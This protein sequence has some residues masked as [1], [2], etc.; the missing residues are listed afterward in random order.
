MQRGGKWWI[1]TPRLEVCWV[2]HLWAGC[3]P[4]QFCWDRSDRYSRMGFLQAGLTGWRNRSDWL[5]LGRGVEVVKCSLFHFHSSSGLKGCKTCNL[6]K[7]VYGWTRFV[8]L[9]YLKTSLC[10][11]LYKTFI[12]L[13]F[14]VIV[15]L[16]PST[17]T[18]AWDYRCCFDWVVGW[19]RTVKLNH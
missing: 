3:A 10:K 6:C 17:P 19:E 15:V 8:K 16:V 18:F 12:V 14:Q 13:Y 5:C 9:T 2:A 11:S 1:E 4:C 7:L